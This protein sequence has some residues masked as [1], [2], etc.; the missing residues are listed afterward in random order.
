MFQMF[1]SNSERKK[2][3]FLSIVDFVVWQGMRMCV[4]ACGG[5]RSSGVPH[6]AW[7]AG[8]GLPVRPRGSPCPIPPSPHPFQSWL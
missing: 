1:V 4:H 8:P 6:P 3:Q 2:T 5:Q 7:R